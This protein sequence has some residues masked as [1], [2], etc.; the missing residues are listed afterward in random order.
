MHFISYLIFTSYLKDSNPYF[1]C[2]DEKKQKSANLRSLF[3]V[4]APVSGK[5][6]IQIQF[7]SH[8]KVALPAER[9]TTSEEQKNR[10]PESSHLTCSM[11]VIG[12]SNVPKGSSPS[13]N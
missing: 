5:A 7:Q 13:E 4:T 8:S 6:M 3:N 12:Q 1:Y 9:N 10:R 11:A 2:A